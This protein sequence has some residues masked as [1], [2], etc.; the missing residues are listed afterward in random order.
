M[1]DL[2]LW[3]KERDFEDMAAD[4]NVS[5]S[6]RESGLIGYWPMNEGTGRL[7]TDKVNSRNL[8]VKGGWYIER[9]G[10]AI[11]MN[12][13][14]QNLLISTGAIPVKPTEDY[15][16]E[17][18][19]KTGAQTNTTMFSCGKGIGDIDA[20]NKLSVGLEG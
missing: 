7:A 8:T 9:M 4:R 12:G 17:F 14:N 10:K 11:Q 20:S 15:S 1:S 6:G 13:T 5:K 2:S 19:F 18:W 3:I 16:V